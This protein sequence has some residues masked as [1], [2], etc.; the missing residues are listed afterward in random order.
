MVEIIFIGT[1][2]SVATLERDNTSF[3]LRD[4]ETMVLVD[5]PGSIV[6]KLH[7]LKVDFRRLNKVFLTHVHPD[8]VYGW[9]SL[10]HSLML[11]E[12]EVFLF[13]SEA[14]VQLGRRLL[15]L[16]QLRGKDVRTRVRFKPLIPEREYS[17]SESWTVMP[18]RVPHHRSSLAYLFHL[19]KEKKKILISGDTPLHAP[20]FEKARGAACLVHDCSAPSWVFRQYPDLF[21]MHTNSLDLGKKCQEVGI[22]FLVPVHFLGEVKFSSTDI[23]KEIQAHFRGRL[24]IPEDLMKIKL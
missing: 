8:H 3:L 5:C 24:V 18:V 2:G 23:K 13:G 21:R 12:G 20:L 6:Q 16:F 22:R 11:E 10:I 9:P 7:K 15:D 1:G 17:L 14:T 19:E 4:R